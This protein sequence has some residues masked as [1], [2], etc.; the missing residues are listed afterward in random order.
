MCCPGHREWLKCPIKLRESRPAVK[1]RHLPN[2]CTFHGTTQPVRTAGHSSL[3]KA[4][5]KNEWSCTSPARHTFAQSYLR[6]I[7]HELITRDKCAVLS[8]PKYCLDV[9]VLWLVTSCSLVEPSLWN[10]SLLSSAVFSLEP[11]AQEAR[12]EIMD[13]RSVNQFTPLPLLCPALTEAWNWSC[14]RQHSDLVVWTVCMV[15]SWLR[16][17]SKIPF[18]RTF[19]HG[20]MVP[21]SLPALHLCCW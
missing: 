10:L 18:R 14:R 3:Y 19:R 16:A 13:L 1:P 15:N 12:N 21:Y 6:C 20:Q 5:V 8:V 2:R 17:G 7:R 4:V 11:L 9:K